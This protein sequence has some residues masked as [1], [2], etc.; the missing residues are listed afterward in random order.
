MPR[1]VHAGLQVSED[2]GNRFP[3][4]AWVQKSVFL[5]SLATMTRR[6]GTSTVADHSRIRIIRLLP[7]LNDAQ[8]HC[9]IEHIELRDD[10][11][12]QKGRH[13]DNGGVRFDAL[14]YAW[15]NATVSPERP[16]ASSIKA[17][18]ATATFR[19]GKVY[20]KSV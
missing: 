10:E 14:S 19:G 9:I 12:R 4:R 3:L 1:K 11:K 2:T 7:G 5:A 16:S 20:Y 17:G 6:M 15:G 13:L 18:L 8:L